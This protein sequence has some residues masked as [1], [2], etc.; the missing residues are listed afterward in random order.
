MKKDEILTAVEHLCSGCMSPLEKT[1]LPCPNCGWLKTMN[2]NVNQLETG[3]ILANENQTAHYIIG[4]SLGQGGFGITYLAWDVNHDEKVVVKE[5]FPTGVAARERD[6]GKVSPLTANQTDEFQ[7]GLVNLLKEAYK[8]LAFNNEPNVVT[9]KDFFR[10][11]NTAYIVMEYV[12]G[13]TL[14]Q[15]LDERG[16]RLPLETVL[17]KLEPI[18]FVLERMHT[19]K[20]DDKGRIVRESLIHRDISPDNIIFTKGGVAKLLDFGSSRP[21]GDN[22]FA[23]IKTG[24]SPPE[25][26]FLN[27]PQGAWTDVYAFAA[28]IYRAITGERVPNAITRTTQDTLVLPS[29]LGVAIEPFQEAALIKALAPDFLKRWQSVAEFVVAMRQPER[30][31]TVGDK[32]YLRAL[33]LSSVGLFI[34]SAMILFFIYAL[35]NAFGLPEEDLYVEM[36]Y[37]ATFLI[38]FIAGSVSTVCLG[39][40]VWDLVRLNRNVQP[41]WL[42]NAFRQDAAFFLLIV[43]AVVF[44]SITLIYADTWEYDFFL[45]DILL[46]EYSWDYNSLYLVTIIVWTYAACSVAGIWL[47]RQ[48]LSNRNH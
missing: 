14:S 27:V 38:P 48:I 46:Y 45:F 21:F 13:Q 36:I 5:Y 31:E 28:T 26:F 1:N 34:S 4:K 42:H 16:G 15:M 10:A 19:A 47:G 6:S 23:V 39:A 35:N 7:N 33:V 2:N 30:T 9:V 18:A 40:Y 24:Y 44:V 11:N 3:F 29:K 25:Q 20:S 17:K 22:L 37:K 41:R 43:C 8:M 32:K 12:D